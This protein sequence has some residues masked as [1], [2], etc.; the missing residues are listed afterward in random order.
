MPLVSSPR[1]TR[2]VTYAARVLA[3]TAL[4]LLPASLVGQVKPVLS[5]AAPAAPAANYWV[6]VGAESADKIYRVRFGP[7]GTV[8]EK[9]IGVG[10]LAA[11]MEGPHGLAISQDGKYLHMTTGHG[12]PDGKYWRYELGTDTLVRLFKICCLGSLT[13]E[14]EVMAVAVS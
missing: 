14:F 6:Y 9:T 7:M 4:P 11:E 5:P 13:S 1:K 12:Y 8:V 3:M 2:R 10:E